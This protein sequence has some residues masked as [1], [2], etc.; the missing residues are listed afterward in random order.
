MKIFIDEIIFLAKDSKIK[1]WISIDNKIQANYC[2]KFQPNI[3]VIVSIDNNKYIYYE[4]FLAYLNTE[5]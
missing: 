1:S 2:G 4:Q 5:K 3:C